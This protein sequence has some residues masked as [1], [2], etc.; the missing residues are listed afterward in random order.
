VGQ[1]LPL[2]QVTHLYSAQPP[3]P[4]A[5]PGSFVTKQ[6]HPREYRGAVEF[7]I[8]GAGDSVADAPAVDDAEQVE[9]VDGAVGVHIARASQCAVVA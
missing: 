7:S 5:S 4:P 2:I 9:Y 8:D 3:G 6:Q 1:H